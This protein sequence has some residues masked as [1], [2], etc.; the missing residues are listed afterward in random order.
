MTP[1]SEGGEFMIVDLFKM[2]ASEARYTTTFV[3]PGLSS[4][5]CFRWLESE[6]SAISQYF[7]HCPSVR[8]SFLEAVQ[9]VAGRGSLIT[10][11]ATPAANVLDDDP[12]VYDSKDG[13]NRTDSITRDDVDERA[14]DEAS[15]SGAGLAVA[16]AAGHQRQQLHQHPLVTWLRR[17]R[18]RGMRPT[19]RSDHRRNGDAPVHMIGYGGFIPSS[20][21]NCP[22]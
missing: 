8:H 15:A 2:E 18:L 5:R 13:A 4:S 20:A 16:S 3:R 12:A 17:W 7:D 22:R 11:A 10:P 14:H 19:C 9:W 1:S 21:M 6:Q